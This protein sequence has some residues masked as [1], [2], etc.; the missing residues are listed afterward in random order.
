MALIIQREMRDPRVGLVSVN[1]VKVSRDLSFADVYVSTLTDSEASERTELVEVL[2]KAAG[3][4]RSE[5]AKR[6]KMR[7]TPKLRFHYDAL[8]ESAP[9]MESLIAQA[10]SADAQVAAQRDPVAEGDDNG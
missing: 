4:F 5:L 8:A 7:T 9:R 6:H 3:Y 1:E 2:N 10:R